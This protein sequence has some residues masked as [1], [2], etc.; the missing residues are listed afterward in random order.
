M[1][2]ASAASPVPPAPSGAA[3]IVSGNPGYRLLGRLGGGAFGE[4]SR[5]KAP[6]GFPAAVKII[7]RSFDHQ[8]AQRELK[9][10][11]ITQGLNHPY[12]LRTE[13]A[14][15][16]EN[17]L[18]IAM[19]LAEGSLADRLKECRAAG[20]P[21]IP[22]PEL[23]RYFREAAEALDWLH[24]KN[25]LHR[26]I[27]P[28]N[29]LILERHAK[30]ADFGLVRLQS[31]G[32]AL[33]ATATFCG[34]MV[35]MPPE[36]WRGKVSRHSDQYSLAVTYAE[37]RLGRPPFSGKNHVELMMEHQ[38]R[39]PNLSPL[40][41]AEQAVLA[42]ALAKKSGER[43]P[44]CL[45]FVQALDEA[46]APELRPS[47]PAQPRSTAPPRGPTATIVA[48]P[49][50][51]RPTVGG[52]KGDRERPRRSAAAW[53]LVLSALL[54]L[55]LLGGYLLKRAF[56]PAT[57]PADSHKPEVPEPR[58]P[59]GQGGGSAILKGRDGAGQGLALT[60]SPPTAR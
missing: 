15:L 7:S 10:L 42:R 13:A 50:V 37:L 30:V 32:A 8:E 47:H 21:G 33:E 34:T 2:G 14:W 5:T 4:V 43:F 26:D 6:G 54:V 60:V 19:E 11:E 22:L 44:S 49:T 28:E 24:G 51:G 52:W 9:A 23:L 45:A 59:V 1:R 20:L 38:Q 55:L 29:I 35:Y 12:L 48:S 17:Q 36:T 53:L 46:M 27:K 56:A 3:K 18:R 16:E 40:P 39:T 58:P 57:A 25:V 31:A 41:P